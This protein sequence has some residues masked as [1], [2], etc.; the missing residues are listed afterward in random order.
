MNPIGLLLGIILVKFY[1][2]IECII[3][4]LSAGTFLYISST[5]VIMEEFEVSKWKMWK[6]ASFMFGIFFFSII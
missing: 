3:I 6:F 5:E 4:S 2:P 1:S